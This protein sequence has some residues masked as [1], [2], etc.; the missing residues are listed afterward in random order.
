M[1]DKP[2]GIRCPRPALAGDFPAAWSRPISKPAS[3][4]ARARSRASCRPI[5]RRPRCATSWPISRSGLIYLA[6]HQR[7][8]GADRAGLRFFVDA[9]LEIGS[10]RA[11]ERAAIDAQV[12]CSPTAA[13][14]V[15]EVL[16]EA[17]NLLSGLSHCA[18]VV[19]APKNNHAAASTSNSSASGAGTGAGD[20]GRRGRHG[21]EPRHRRAG[22]PA[23]VGASRGPRTSLDRACQGKTIAEVQRYRPRRAGDAQ[24]RA[25]RADREGGR[26]GHR[27]LVGR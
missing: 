9:L 7:R 22:R 24:A 27:H 26:G 15:E 16:T 18:G 6:P 19:V 13:A 10:L 3:R 1:D 4:S 23:A 5:C 17:T 25:R 14:G 21:R 2:F 12:G 8:P 11:E 20:A